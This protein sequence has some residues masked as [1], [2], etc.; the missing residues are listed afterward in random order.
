MWEPCK[1]KLFFGTQ[2][3]QNPGIHSNSVYLSSPPSPTWLP[4]V[5]LNAL[6]KHEVDP[7]SLK[8]ANPQDRV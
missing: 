3:V 7:T 4:L 2:K 8:S 5:D 1:L 6:V